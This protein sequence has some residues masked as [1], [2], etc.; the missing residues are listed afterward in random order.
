MTTI[1]RRAR[2]IE[3][4][5]VA[6]FTGEG[7]YHGSTRPRPAPAAEAEAAPL[8][9]EVRPFTL[10]R[11]AAEGRLEIDEFDARFPRTWAI[12]ERLGAPTEDAIVADGV[13]F[14]W[15]PIDEALREAGPLTRSVIAAMV[16]HVVGDKR[17][18]YIDS[19]IQHFEAGDAPVDSQHWHVDGTSV[20]RDPR[21]QRLGHALLHDLRARLEGPVTPPRFLA[22]QSSEH[23]ATRFVD[24]PLSLRLPELIPNF[25]ALD[26][27]VRALDPPSVA[28]PAGSI[29]GFDGLTL[30]RAVAAAGAGWR[31]WVR[32]VET[33]R[34]VTPSPT[35]IE[36]YGTVYRAG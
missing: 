25:D 24:A 35:M 15:C 30:H 20:A 1:L 6:R 19:K 5:Q 27:R 26:R 36:C 14:C 10:E 3:R 17:H 13:T 4:Q 32:C 34:A 18:V 29:V 2:A 22:Y 31:L 11:Y 21:A 23:C 9:D 8:V 16:P 33:D 12:R 28:Q 7:A